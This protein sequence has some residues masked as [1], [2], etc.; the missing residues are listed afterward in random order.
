MERSYTAF[1]HLLS[2]E[3]DLVTQLDRV[4]DGY[5]T[6][7]W[8]ENEIVIDTFGLP[9]PSELQPGSYVVQTGFYYLPT[10]ERLGEPQILGD[11][12]IR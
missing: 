6:S 8:H 1:V 2:P 11:I 4:P 12:I 7:D 3:G 10:L 5:L 9:L